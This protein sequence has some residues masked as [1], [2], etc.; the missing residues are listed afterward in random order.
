MRI[1]YACRPMQ[2]LLVS[3]DAARCPRALMTTT[4]E[5]TTKTTTADELW[6][7]E[8]TGLETRKWVAAGK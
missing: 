8:L 4:I 6:T 2:D 1:G 7:R 5:L 3:W